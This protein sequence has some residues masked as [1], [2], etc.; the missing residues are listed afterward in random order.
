MNTRKSERLD[1]MRMKD[2]VSQLTDVIYLL[3]EAKNMN[4]TL[5]LS[6]FTNL[7]EAEQNSLNI[8]YSKDAPAARQNPSKKCA[9]ERTQKSTE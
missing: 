1:T 2:I 8:I 4:I 9:K 5:I 7:T 6:Q 3:C